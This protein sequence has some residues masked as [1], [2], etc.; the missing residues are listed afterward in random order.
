[1]IYERAP[2][3]I[4]VNP[5]AP[6]KQNIL[7]M[8]N[9]FTSIITIIVIALSVSADSH[10]QSRT[11]DDIL[12]TQSFFRDTRVARAPYGE[13]FYNYDN[14]DFLDITTAGVQLGVGIDDKIEIAA[15]VYYINRLPDEVDG[16]SGVADVPLYAR[17][18]FSDGPTKFSGGLFATIPIGSEE[19]GE[20]NLNFGPFVAVRHPVS[21]VVALT[22]TL[23]VDFLDTAIEDYEA[24]MNFGGGVIYHAARKLFVV[25][26][27]KVMSDLDYSAISGGLNYQITKSVHLRTNLLLGLDENAPDFGLRAGVIVSPN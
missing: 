25:G 24:S 16:A 4:A 18:Q 14:F 23:G 22:G 9:L 2:Q 12:L 17:Y 27:I 5:E 1:M 10:A 13:A 20:G 8:R 26:D 15:G 19:I 6:A 3:E 11:Y 21:D 7:H